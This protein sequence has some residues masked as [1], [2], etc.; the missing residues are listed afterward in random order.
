MSN[1]LAI[2]AVTLTLRSLLEAGLV[3][4]VP[5]TT[6][7]ML[8]LDVVRDNGAGNQ[9]NL[10][11]Y[12]SLLSPTW[13]NM[14][15]PGQVQPGESGHPPLPL[16]LYYLVTA[17]GQNNDEMMAHR[18]LGR[19]MSLLHDHPLLGPAEIEAATQAEL[20][21]SDLHRQVERIR[22]TPQPLSL[23]EMT[24]LWAAVQNQYRPTAAYE[25]SVLLIES[26][27][28]TLTPLPVLRRGPAD[29]G[30][31]AQADLVPPFP[32]LDGIDLPDGQPAARLG[33][34]ITLRGHHLTGNLTVRFAHPQ[35]EAAIEVAPAPGG[36]PTM[37]AV[38]LPDAPD[39]WPAGFYRVSVAIS[40]SGTVTRSTNELPLAL[41]PVVESIAPD[42]APTDG[43]GDVT[44]TV[45][46]R[47]EIWP[48]QRAALLLGN[49]EVPAE[50]HLTRTDTLTFVV[51]GAPLGEQ[52]FRLRV[53]GAD[54]LLVD[55]SASPPIFDPSQRVTIT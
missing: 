18:L 50:P 34:T 48:G 16:N 3:S 9:V 22:V 33:Q 17:Y 43:N 45:S 36:G 13:R 10:F 4:D 35:L 23:D 24:K 52:L 28:A 25:V 53:D 40:E 11:L 12:H 54:S 47:P 55:R 49:R 27:R 21:G 38:T 32:A 39:Q 8:P 51:R 41:A 14:P 44:L 42:P 5:G 15:L 20:P 30:V 7:T 19:A 1:S 2:A 29:E 46:A 31:T 37:Q 26:T 6:V